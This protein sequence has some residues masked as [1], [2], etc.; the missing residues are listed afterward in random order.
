MRAALSEH[1]IL[2]TAWVYAAH[3]HNFVKT[4][5][6]FGAERPSLKVVQD[7][8]GSPTYARDLAVFLAE[9]IE[10]DSYGIFHAS[11]TGTCSW[12]EFAQAIFV[13]RGMQV[14]VEPCTTEEFP[15]PAPRPRYSVLD[16]LA[17]RA[18]GL[19]DL[20]PW[21]EALREFLQEQRG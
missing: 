7:Q 6:K 12:Y 11:N 13:E 8:V 21:R 15:R 17:I 1:V 4:M 10:T 3:G 2:R 20:R 16:H 19:N 5:L 18:Q 9:L 14:Q